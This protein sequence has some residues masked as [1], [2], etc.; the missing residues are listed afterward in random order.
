MAAFDR[1]ANG[2]MIYGAW[3]RLFRVQAMV[4]E[5]RWAEA[6]GQLARDIQ[7]DLREDNHEHIPRRRQ[8]SAELSFLLGAETVSQMEKL[9]DDIPFRRTSSSS[10]MRPC[11]QPNWATDA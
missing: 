11:W 2:G 9:A 8:W 10:G 4:Y 7:A 6:I 5:G 3:A 1:L